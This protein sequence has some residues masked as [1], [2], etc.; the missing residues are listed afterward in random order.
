MS[1]SNELR[2][3]GNKGIFTV[4]NSFWQGAVGFLENETINL[5]NFTISEVQTTDNENFASINIISLDSLSFSKSKKMVLTTTA[6]LENEGLQW[7]STLTSLTNH[8]GGRSLCEPVKAKIKFN[9]AV[10]DSFAVYRLNERGERDK[11]ISTTIEN[12]VAEFELN[13]KT[14]W[15]EISNHG[16][17]EIISSTDFANNKSFNFILM[18]N[19]FN[20]NIKLIIED[21]QNIDYKLFVYNING[22]LVYSDEFFLVVLV[23]N[24]NIPLSVIYLRNDIDQLSCCLQNSPAKVIGELKGFRDKVKEKLSG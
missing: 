8:G 14:L 17:V 23:A 1:S 21:K 9:N 11:S 19:P 10:V 18:P 5:K 3:D 4:D 24:T 12:G 13:E 20:E 16:T 2:W 22:T 7:N 15:Y 6:R